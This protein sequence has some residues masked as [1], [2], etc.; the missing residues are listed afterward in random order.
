VIRG[1]VE[2]ELCCEPQRRRQRG[3]RAPIGHLAVAAIPVAINQEFIAMVARAGTSNLF[4]LLWASAAHE[5]IVSRAIGSSFLEISNSNSWP[6]AAL[7]DTLLPKLSSGELR[8]KA[9]G[10][11]IGRAV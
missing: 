9:A 1:Q 2:E 11:F 8:G 3:L 7:R 6:I 5:A 10:E 4:L